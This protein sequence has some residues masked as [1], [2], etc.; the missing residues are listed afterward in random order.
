[1]TRPDH[2]N[3]S[4]RP[5]RGTAAAYDTAP[6]LELAF[7][8][9]KR[10]MSTSRNVSFGKRVPSVSKAC[11]ANCGHPACAHG[12]TLIQSN[13]MTELDVLNWARRH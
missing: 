7:Y 1:M 3:S 11:A 8:D 4:L 2:R 6:A 5:A 12:C 9:A 10:H 13:G